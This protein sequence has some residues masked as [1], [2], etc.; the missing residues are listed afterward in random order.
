[1]LTRLILVACCLRPALG[2]LRDRDLPPASNLFPTIGVLSVPE[3][4][5]G[6]PCDTSTVGSG[7]SCFTTFY[8]HWLQSAGARA[9][10]LPVGANTSTLDVLLDS[11]NG[12][13]FTGGGVENFTFSNPFMA[14]AQYIYARVL[15]K[16]D[17][18]IFMPLHGTCQ[19]MQV[20]ATLTS[21][22]E[23]IV[24]MY[25]FDS[26]NMSI[27]LDITWD[28]HHASRL[29]NAD[30]A[31]GGVVGTLGGAPVTINLHHDGVRVGAFEEDDSLG[32][33]YVLASTNFDRR[34]QAFVSTMEGWDYPI[35][36]TQWHPERNACVRPSWPQAGAKQEK[37]GARPLAPNTT[38]PNPPTRGAPPPPAQVRVAGPF[39]PR[40]AQPRGDCGDA[41]HGDV[42]RHRCAEE[43]AGLLRPRPFRALLCVFV[44]HRERARRRN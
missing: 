43:H 27:P 6:T 3:Q 10:I 18:G 38:P 20:L 33:F 36:G 2:S 24:S 35:V 28:G 30:T 31:P 26:E 19:G 11:V 23:S 13:L 37:H 44:P 14:T 8:M 1:M 29:F 42:F 32:D 5:G 12:V 9:I 17:A 16:N 7:A 21:R 34:G 22:N 15:A 25:A 41:V 40:G 39:L 4:A